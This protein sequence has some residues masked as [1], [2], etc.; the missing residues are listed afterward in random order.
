MGLYESTVQYIITGSYML[1]NADNKR[2]VNVSRKKMHTKKGKK[3][4]QGI[5]TSP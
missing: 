4:G 2:K 1:L 5:R 3:K